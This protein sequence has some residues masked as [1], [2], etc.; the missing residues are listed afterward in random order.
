M[1]GF[2]RGLQTGKGVVKRWPKDGL[3]TSLKPSEP[4][5]NGARGS[6][7]GWA[8]ISP[9]SELQRIA[10]CHGPCRLV[11]PHPHRQKARPGCWSLHWSLA[12]DRVVVAATC[13]AP[14]APWPSA[15]GSWLA[16]QRGTR[17]KEAQERKRHPG[18]H[19]GGHGL[20]IHEWSCPFHS[21]HPFNPIS[22]T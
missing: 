20:V 19:P 8:D 21:V 5:G 18:R 6:W 10:C 11:V 13:C 12:W 1:Q 14:L 15:S 2:R 22:L 7:F 9:S 4:T 3:C 17:G 16:G